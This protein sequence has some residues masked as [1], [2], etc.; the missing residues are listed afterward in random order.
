MSERPTK[1]KCKRV[2]T[3][4]PGYVRTFGTGPD[5]LEWPW[6]E[7]SRE[8]DPH[9]TKHTTGHHHANEYEGEEG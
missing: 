1:P 7:D 6:E 3:I 8:D 4:P 5:A 2:L 9:T